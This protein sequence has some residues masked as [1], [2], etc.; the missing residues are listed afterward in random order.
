[1]DF[2]VVMVGRC[3]LMLAGPEGPEALTEP[4]LQAQ[5]E[6]SGQAG[7]AE[8]VI[9]DQAAPAVQEARPVQQATAEQET[10]LP[11]PPITVQQPAPV[12]VV[13]VVRQVQQA[14][15]VS[16]EPVAALP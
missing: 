16:T 4:A 5:M 2:Q 3:R 8:P 12:A 6:A 15:A 10:S 9:M 1:M 14:L 7:P 11:Q 13:A